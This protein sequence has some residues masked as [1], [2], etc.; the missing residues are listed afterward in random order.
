MT[1]LICI[2]ELMKIRSL[3]NHC[4]GRRDTAVCIECRAEREREAALEFYRRDMGPGAVHCEPFP[5]KL[6]KL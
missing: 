3:P 2:R 4:L 1:D 5:E 6:E